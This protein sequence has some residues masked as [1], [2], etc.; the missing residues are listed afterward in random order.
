LTG[1]TITGSGAMTVTGNF[2]WTGGTITNSGSTNIS[3]GASLT[4]TTGSHKYLYIG[5]INNQ[6][7][8]TWSST[9]NFYF[10]NGA[11]FNNSGTF[12]V[13]NNESI[14]LQVGNTSAFNNSGT[15]TKSAGNTNSYST[16]PFNN[17]GTVNV[18]TG[19]FNLNGG[20][21]SS[22]QPVQY[23]SIGGGQHRKRYL[24]RQHRHNF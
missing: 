23:L 20:G 21:I 12:D 6:G 14:S 16:V 2:N 5:A 19:T 1:G 17:T 10:Y 22:S 3:P 4:L 18:L 15:F 8:T 11:T 24:Y 7:T 9:G 13:Q